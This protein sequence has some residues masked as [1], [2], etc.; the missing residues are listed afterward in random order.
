MPFASVRFRCEVLHGAAELVGD[1]REDFGLGVVLSAFD[2]GE[3]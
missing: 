1:S 3:V 2:A